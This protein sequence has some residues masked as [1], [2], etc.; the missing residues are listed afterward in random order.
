MVLRCI[1]G[2]NQQC[3]C[4]GLREAGQYAAVETLSDERRERR[5]GRRKGRTQHSN[6][7]SSND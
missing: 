6:L 1:I 3:S 2:S 7:R 4:V 5:P